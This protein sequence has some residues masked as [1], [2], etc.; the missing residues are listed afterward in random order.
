MK[1]IIAI[2]IVALSIFG[3]TACGNKAETT[4]NT[5]ANANTNNTEIVVG[6]TSV[7]HAEILNEVVDDL[8]TQGITLSIKEFSD[9][10]LLNRSLDEGEIDANFFQHK[11]YL[12]EDMKNSGAKLVSVGPIHTE[13]MG[14]YSKT[15]TSL[16]ELEDGAKVAIPNDASNGARALLLLAENGLITLKEGVAE[17]ATVMDIEEN[18]KNIEIM[19]L[20]AAT[21]PRT[22]DEVSMSVINTNYALAGGLN[23]MEDA[24]AFE[25]IDSP[26]AN[27]LVVREGDENREEIQALYE[28]LTT[29][30][31]RTFIEENYTG[32]IIPAF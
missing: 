14:A 12:D 3:L 28:A 21:L 11:A 6:A 10:S 24:I 26:Y 27:I 4:E 1:K 20:D 7:P 18:P 31:I 8:E 25:S 2:G 22:L 9:Y 13:P 29:E 5:D 17:G 19:E 32:A 30:E 16:D 15:I 23:P